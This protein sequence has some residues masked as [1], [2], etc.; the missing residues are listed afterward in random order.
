[1]STGAVQRFWFN[2]RIRGQRPR[3]TVAA[4]TAAALIAALTVP[5]LSPLQAAAAEPTPAALAFTVQP[6]DGAPGQALGAQPSVTIEDSTGAAVASSTTTVTLTLTGPDGAALTG[7]PATVSCGQTTSGTTDMAATAGVAAFTGCATSRGGLFTLTATDATDHL[8]AVSSE[9]FVSG[10]A[11]LAFVGQ[12]GGGSGGLIWGAQPQVAVEDARGTVVS[13]STATISLAIQAGSG[14]TGAALACTADPATAS[15]GVATFAGCAIGAAS[16]GYRL[17]ATDSTDQLQA[18]SAAFTVAA[19]PPAALVF[20][21]QPFAGTGG[22]ALGAQ[23]TVAVEDAGGNVIADDSDQIDLT[24]KSDS[25]TPG[26]TLSCGSNP[27]A[28]TAGSAAFTGCAIDAT[29]SGYRLVATDS[30]H[31]LT[32]TSAPFDVTAGSASAVTFSTQ[33]SG[34]PGGEPFTTQPTVTVTDAGGNGISSPVTLAIKADTGTSGASLTCDTTLVTT[35]AKG[36]ATFTGCGIDKTGTGYVLTA[37]AG[38]LTTASAPFDVTTG[39][40]AHVAFTTQPGDTTGGEDLSTAPVVHLTDAGGAPAAGS[41]T[42]SLT[43][44]TGATGATLRCA[45]NPVTATKGAAAFDGCAIDKAGT[46]RLTAT[47]GAVTATSAPF[48]VAVGAPARL[49]FTTQPAGGSGGTPWTTSPVVTIEDAGGNIVTTDSVTVAL[50]VTAGS[51]DG[52]L[53]CAADGLPAVRGAAVFAG[54]SVDAAATAYTLTAT[55]AHDGL[56]TT[57]ATF[58]VTAGA[59]SRLVFSTQPSTGPAKTAFATAPVVTVVD[60]GGNTVGTTD[61]IDLALTTGTGANGAKLTC[62]ATGVAATSGSATFTG[63]AVDTAAAG[64]TLTATDPAAGLA[65]ESLPFSVLPPLP[66]PLGEAPVGVPAAQTMGG[67]AWGVNPTAVTDDVNT[68][69]GALTFGVTDLRVAGI[70]E[71]LAVQRTY[72]SNDTSG[73][74]FGPGWT[75]LLDAGVTIEDRHT[76]VVR[77][78]DGQQLIFTKASNGNAGPWTG[79][80]GAQASLFCTAKTCTVTRFDGEQLTLQLGADGT[81]RI[82]A[83]RDRDGQGLTFAWS[84]SSVVITVDTTNSR[85]YT[86]TATLNGSGQVTG[87]ST[88]AGRTVAYGYTGGLLTSV[89]D[90]DGNTWTYGYS[91]GLLTSEIDPLGVARLTATY[92]TSERVTAIALTGSAQLADDTFTWDA[93][94]A[95]TGTATASALRDVD[96]SL[97]RE[98]SVDTYRGNVLIAQTRPDG[99][100][101]RYSY[102]DQVNLTETQDPLGWVQQF[103]YDAAG[104]LTSQ[105]EPTGG[106]PTTASMTYNTAHQLLTQTDAD[107]NTTSYAY[108]GPNLTS[109]TPPSG[110]KTT[111][112]YNQVGELTKTTGPLSSQSFGYDEAGNRTTVVTLDGTGHPVNDKGSIESYDEAGDLV[113]ATDAVGTA[114]GSAA[115]YTTTWSYD[116]DGNMLSTTT[117]GPRTTSY[118]YDAAGDLAAATDPTG[119]TTTYSWDETTRTEKRTTDASA[120]N[121]QTYDPSGDLLSQTGPTGQGTSYTY[122]ADGLTSSTTSADDVTV[123]Q[124]YDLDG[125]PVL[126]TDT[127]GNVVSRQY[128]AQGRMTREDSDGAVTLTAYD[129]AGNVVSTT[130]PDGNVST[131]TYSPAGQVT[132]VSTAAGTT[133]Y[134]YDPAGDLTSVTDPGGSETAYGYQAPGLRTTMTVG[135]GTALAATTSYGYDADGR[136][137]STTDPDGRTTTETLNAQGEPTTTEYTEPGQSSITVSRTYDALGRVQTMTDSTGNHDYTYNGASNLLS[138]TGPGGAFHYDFSQPGRITETYPDGTAIAYHVDDAGNLMSM[139]SGTA[140]QPDYVAA[141]Y[142]RNSQRQTTAVAYSNGVLETRQLDQSGDVLDQAIQ[143]TGSTLG[144]DAFSYDADG[145]PLSQ[146]DT[147]AGTQTTDQYG[148]DGAGRITSFTTSSQTTPTTQSPQP[149]SARSASFQVPGTEVGSRT[150]DTA[151]SAANAA[152]GGTAIAVTALDVTGPAAG[153]PN[154]APEPTSSAVAGAPVTAAMSATLAATSAA[155]PSTPPAPTYHYDGAGNITRSTTASGSTTSSYNS[156]GEITSSTG[157]DGATTYAYDKRGDLLAAHGPE[158]SQAYTY[159]AADQLVSVTTTGNGNDHSVTYSYD[160]NGNRV[161]ATVDGKTTDYLWD[162]AGAYPRLAIEQTSSGALVHRYLYGDGPVAMQTPTATYFYHVDPT[163]NVAELTD[164]SGQVAVAYH[165]DPFGEVTAT[166]PDGRTAPTNP[167]L[168]QGQYQD[169]ITGLYD[170]RARDYDPATGRFTQPDPVTPTAGTSATSPYVF[171]DDN[172]LSNADPTGTVTQDEV[173]QKILDVVWSTPNIGVNLATDLS[174]A[175]SLTKAAVKLNAFLAKR[176]ASKAASAVEE[177]ASDVGSDAEP[178]SEIAGDAATAEGALGELGAGANAATEALAGTSTLSKFADVG[179]AL[180]IIGIGLQT[181]LTVEACES[182][183]ASVCAGDIVGESV[184]MVFF[185]G[186]TA[187]T[188]GFMAGVCAVAGIAMSTGLQQVV[189]RYGP[190]IYAGL[191]SG[192][193]ASAAAIAPLIPQTA[194]A[195]TT[196]GTAIAGFATSAGGTI[197]SGFNRSTAAIASGFDGMVSTLKGAGYTA[198][199]LSQVLATTFDEGANDV[200]AALIGAGYDIGDVAQAL[201]ADF[202]TTAEQAAALLKDGYG[203]TATEVATALNDA[204]DLSDAAAAAVLQGVGFAAGE[205]AVA[206]H[207]AYDDTAAAVASALQS[208]KDGLDETTAALQQAFGASDVAMAGTLRTLDYTASQVAASLRQLYGDADEATATALQDAGYAVD[209]VATALRGVYADGAQAAA[210]VLNSTD[211]TSGDIAGALDTVYSLADATTAQVLKTVGFAADDVAGA[212]K[213]AYGVADS[214][215]A[216]AMAGAGYTAAQVAGAL[217]TAYSDGD[218]AAATALKAAG[219]GIDQVAAAL[220]SAFDDTD[221]AAAKALAGADYAAAQVA[222]ALSSA[223]A[224]GDTLA[225]A[226]L[227][228]AGY[229]INA[230]SGAL[231]STYADTAQRAA[232][233]LKSLGYTASEVSGAL[234]TVYNEAASGVA[235]VLA[236]VGYGASDIAN[237]LENA[238]NEGSSAVANLLSSIGFSNSTIQSIGGAFASFGQSVKDCFTS[239]FSDC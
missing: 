212:L 161:S 130:D 167:L 181:Y 217:S 54:C 80:A 7:V 120:T 87:I 20:T 65:A 115:D 211:Y 48:A 159:N 131:A 236:E 6:G 43:A 38:S 135:A 13:T 4:L 97:V 225:A 67:R 143:A 226:A 53:T 58:A 72:N 124:T 151:D 52:T 37:T 41:V 189:T 74:A 193:T 152:P 166:V 136:I 32:A 91:G 118:T 51:G 214:V 158:S 110:G 40:V 63:C 204:Y 16:T 59:P 185:V 213:S 71:P 220:S 134:G 192:Y 33:P 99:G 26:A 85:P 8:T 84:A 62:A 235:H 1:M 46:Y 173:K 157:P 36:V 112:A 113:S 25:G 156:L 175:N 69:T 11:Q 227:Q 57:S 179:G 195:L 201:G 182:A 188:E 10:P 219:Y 12:P 109:I 76:A 194:Q 128:D 129:A 56:T 86:V 23:P 81:S 121:S 125:D 126:V 3:A 18:V 196:A 30:A 145:N 70:G 75:S 237:V 103:T 210:T 221:A 170:M 77:G 223:Y 107:G 150:T 78:D 106:R 155:A 39:A 92:G 163:G 119:A 28:A 199:E 198:G 116:A 172:P 79:P 147:V 171:A 21:T 142:Q 216:A 178:I 108:T 206:L 50:A 191:A 88:P 230:I 144:D 27:R 203:Y 138:A 102:D 154:P 89:T 205:T 177:V 29:G 44:G 137:V 168:F 5:L 93:T 22:S 127:A 238:F 60:A 222:G 24:I 186:C 160:G 68:A 231:S 114:T 122:N 133:A 105:S 9:F 141:A 234:A 100:V 45:A 123:R 153:I 229:S 180:Q 34:G 66:A 164:G 111:L 187:V 17:V 228:A 19:G 233:V 197:A 101:T 162:P 209:D 190:Q 2:R 149:I 15:K 104:D 139:S 148:Y 202:G 183:S 31:G 200:A 239:F 49:A 94:T 232:T 207:A 132:S 73:G 169:P 215:A 184:S 64:Y 35:N 146:T 47:S 117:P 176:A 224:D 83:D 140:G 165:Y 96:G 98:P 55:D 61:T 14:A 95:T 90:A 218:Q 208:V 42:L 82:T 174:Y